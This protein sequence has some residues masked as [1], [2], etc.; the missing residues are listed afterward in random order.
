MINYWCACIVVLYETCWER[1]FCSQ[2]SSVATV[3]T[4]CLQWP[5]M[6]MMTLMLPIHEAKSMG[7]FVKPMGYIINI[8]GSCRLVIGELLNSF[9]LFRLHIRMR[10]NNLLIS[11][12]EHML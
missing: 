10:K 9:I 4:I 8:P 5:A 1:G 11:Q 12:P 2:P 7:N 6:G 3:P